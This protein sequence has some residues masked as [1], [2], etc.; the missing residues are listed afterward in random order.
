MNSPLTCSWK[1]SRSSRVQTFSRFRVPGFEIGRN[2]PVLRPTLPNGPIMSLNVC[3]LAENFQIFNTPLSHKP[4]CTCVLWGEHNVKRPSRRRHLLYFTW[5]PAS[6]GN[7]LERKS[8]RSSQNSRS[9]SLWKTPKD[10]IFLTV[11]SEGELS[12]ISRWL[13]QSMAGLPY[14][15]EDATQEKMLCPTSHGSSSI[16]AV[17]LLSSDSAPDEYQNRCAI[18]IAS[19][20]VF[21]VAAF[22]LLLPQCL[23]SCTTPGEPTWTNA[24]MVSHFCGI[25]L[26][27]SAGDPERF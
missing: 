20:L 22:A 19:I 27:S 5:N 25:D 21:R 15:L 11:F 23:L 14:W 26:Y 4:L 1:I 16:N 17:G 24:H 9:D 2:R 18:T 8:L 3:F 13:I 6:P 12:G 7:G 10:Q